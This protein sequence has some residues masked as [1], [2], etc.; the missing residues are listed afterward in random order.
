MYV[1]AGQVEL[2]GERGVANTLAVL[3]QGTTIRVRAREQRAGL[4][5]AAAK[6]LREPIAH[7]G[8]FVM[9]TDAEL[10]QAFDDYRS[11]R[12]AL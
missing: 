9:N 4:L 10:M 11:G 12:L 5:L 3:G 6:P 2:C 7:R 1:H 8:P